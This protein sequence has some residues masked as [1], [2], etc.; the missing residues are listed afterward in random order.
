MESD[1]YQGVLHVIFHKSW[2]DV[3][4]ICHKMAEKCTRFLAAQHNADDKVKTT[5]VHCALEHFDS[6]NVIPVE[7]VRTFI[8]DEF[9]GRGQYVIMKKTEKPPKRFYHYE[10][11]CIYIIKASVLNVKLVK[12]LSPDKLEQLA[13]QWIDHSEPVKRTPKH[14]ECS[15][16]HWEIIQEVKE[17]INKQHKDKIN[18]YTGGLTGEYSF[19]LVYRM[20]LVVLRK[21]K[22]RT[23]RNELERFMITI[24]RDDYNFEDKVMLAIK[25]NIFRDN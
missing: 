2:A 18:P 5:H 16:T 24:I 21:Y 25:K 23:S 4:G 1:V 14:E 3:S 9:K 17:E 20:L 11:L 10:T 22:I 13:S 19:E 8:P 15:K 6:Q 7:G 12:N